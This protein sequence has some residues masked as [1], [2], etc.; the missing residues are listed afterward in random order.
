MSNKR[1]LTDREGTETSPKKLRVSSLVCTLYLSSIP[2]LIINMQGNTEKDQGHVFHASDKQ[3]SQ[4][5]PENNSNIDNPK[6]ESTEKEHCARTALRPIGKQVNGSKQSPRNSLSSGSRLSFDYDTPKIPSYNFPAVPPYPLQPQ[7]LN[8]NH[9]SLPSLPPILDPKMESKIFTHQGVLTADQARNE[10]HSYDQL[11]LVG[12]AYIELIAT[13]LLFSQFPHLSAG[14]L[15]QAREMLVKNETLAG[16]STNYSFDKRAILPGSHKEIANQQGKL[17]VKAMGDIFEAYVAAV[18]MSDP[19]NGFSTAEEWLTELWT[20]K[21]PGLAKANAPLT[22][23]N[24]KQ[25]LS[26]KINS[27]GTKVEYRDEHPPEEVR[28]QG[29]IWFY[30]GAYFTGWGWED[31]HLGSGRGLN[32]VEAGGQAAAQALANPLTERIASAKRV[33]DTRAKAEK[34]RE[35]QEKEARVKE[36]AAKS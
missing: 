26:A 10:T 13:R 6:R 34:E 12:D 32:K 4:H 15:S 9:Y 35:M 24:A 27:K 30:I 1:S 3:V 28:K 22:H 33:G 14:R 20:P 19:A 11:E 2:L 17:W 29:K 8:P 23:T 25:T 16:Y 21:L 7:R 31:V 18:I 36:E 5:C